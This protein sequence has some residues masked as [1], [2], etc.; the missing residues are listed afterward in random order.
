ML[1]VIHIFAYRALHQTMVIS[2]PLVVTDSDGFTTLS[3]SLHL[4]VPLN[5]LEKQVG[6]YFRIYDST[7][8]SMADT[9]CPHISTTSMVS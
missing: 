5:A 6:C 9:C 7:R 3:I 2:I 1:M 8:D 4:Y